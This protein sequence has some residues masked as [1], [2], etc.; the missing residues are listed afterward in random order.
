MRRGR[1]PPPP[2][3]EPSELTP[4]TT[5]VA[6]YASQALLSHLLNLKFPS[7]PLIGEEDTTSLRSSAEQATSMR[8]TI[9]DLVN[10][11]LALE[12]GDVG[13]R[14]DALTEDQVLEAID[15]GNSEGGSNGRWWTCDPI[16]G[17]LGPSG[18]G[19]TELKPSMC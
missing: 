19:C 16:D 13:S 9:V 5:A 17:T 2:P 8:S 18:A 10:E 14:L 7:D 1:A 4:L 3:S 12:G 15:R 6:D 11:A